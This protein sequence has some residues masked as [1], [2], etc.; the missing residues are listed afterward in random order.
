M[1]AFI[2][3]FQFIARDGELPGQPHLPTLIHYSL[4]TLGITG[5][6]MAISLAL[7]LPLGLLLGHLH[8]GSFVAINL[9]NVGRALPSLVVLAIGFAF[10]GIGLA[11]VLLALVVLAV[12][13]IVT[14]AYVGVD[15][16]DAE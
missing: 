15:Q 1:H 10:L 12:P 2:Q 4:G 9:G 6:A 5:I 11:N 16:V 7:G 14:N 8:R 13:P 3:A